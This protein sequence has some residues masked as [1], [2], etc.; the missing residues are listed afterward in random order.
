MNN[1]PHRE[2]R[3]H[4]I[5]LSDPPPYN[6]VINELHPAASTTIVQT[7]QQS[8][9]TTSNAV[10]LY[11]IILVI[12]LAI[13]VSLNII[14]LINMPSCFKLS[15]HASTSKLSLQPWEFSLMTKN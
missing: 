1:Y 5:D 2:L 9:A 15:K 8:S 14:V 3:L 10:V 7:Q 6:E 12:L 11:Y 4:S 13:S